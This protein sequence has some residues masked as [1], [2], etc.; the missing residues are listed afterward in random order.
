MRI[1]SAG[2]FAP[3]QTMSRFN[4]SG[5]QSTPEGQENKIKPDVKNMEF[6]P[7]NGLSQD[8]LNFRI[9]KAINESSK[10]LQDGLH[11]IFDKN[12]ALLGGKTSAEYDEHIKLL[13]KA[14]EGQDFKNAKKLIDKF[15]SGDSTKL[16]NRVQSLAKSAEDKFWNNL[17][18][19][20]S[21]LDDDGALFKLEENGKMS[22]DLT[23]LDIAKKALSTARSEVAAFSDR[24]MTETINSVRTGAAAHAKG[25]LENAGQNRYSEDAASVTHSASEYALPRMFNSDDR[26]YEEDDKVLEDIRKLSEDDSITQEQIDRLTTQN[27]RKRDS[28]SM[29]MRE[30]SD[31]F[32]EEFGK[33]TNRAVLVKEGKTDLQPQGQNAQTEEGVAVSLLAGPQQAQTQL[34]VAEFEKISSG[35]ETSG[36]PEKAAQRYSAQQHPDDWP[37]FDTEA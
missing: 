4:L 10:Y 17:T 2:G 14:I 30:R 3:Q 1:S 34:T 22:E 16:V 24:D 31:R 7:S 20:L 18:E 35:Y 5:N 15:F 37:Y 25:K 23:L 32:L 6:T 28:F 8:N 21:F 33:L 19:S 36:N 11:K 26:N 9:E 13:S 12:D 27:K 29:Y